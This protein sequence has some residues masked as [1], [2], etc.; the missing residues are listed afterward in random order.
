MKTNVCQMTTTRQR[1]RN[2][3]SV[4]KASLSSS[5][6]CSTSREKTATQWNAWIIHQGYVPLSVSKV[7]RNKPY[8]TSI[9]FISAPLSHHIIIPL[10]VHSSN[11]C[12]I[13]VACLYQTWGFDATRRAQSGCSHYDECGGEPALFGQISDLCP[14]ALHESHSWLLFA[15]PVQRCW[16][17]AVKEATYCFTSEALGP[18][19]ISDDLGTLHRTEARV[20]T[21]C[22]YV[23]GESGDTYVDS[24]TFTQVSRLP[25]EPDRVIHE[26]TNHTWHLTIRSVSPLQQPTNILQNNISKTLPAM[27]LWAFPW[28]NTLQNDS[29]IS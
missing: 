27:H 17:Q 3:T 24:E 6:L 12:G 26:G 13:M 15:Q 19:I 25:L 16:H 11:S 28:K 23:K 10:T 8:V 9:S 4:L 20:S 5:S 1:S 7:V 2:L 22:R 29:V 18:Y 14:P 21:S